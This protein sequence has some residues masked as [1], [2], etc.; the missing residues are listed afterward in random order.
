[1]Q[2]REKFASRLGFLL[3]SA[4]CAIGLGNVWRFPYITGKYG[5]AAFLLV[6]LTFLVILGLPV[7]VMEFAVGRASQKSCAKSFEV[8]APGTKWRH[9]K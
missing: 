8:L 5:G 7:M 3:I 2:Q 4:G 1:M 6:Y 9:F